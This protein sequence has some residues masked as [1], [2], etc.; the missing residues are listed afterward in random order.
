ME[1]GRDKKIVPHL[2]CCKW[3]TL[4]G[5]AF[6]GIC[7]QIVATLQFLYTSSILL[8]LTAATYDFDP[9]LGWHGCMCKRRK[10]VFGEF[11]DL[12][13]FLKGSM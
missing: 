4:F 6:N 8:T 5:L 1:Q 13:F 2:P 12:F 11:I 10:A 7:M 3:S 9:S